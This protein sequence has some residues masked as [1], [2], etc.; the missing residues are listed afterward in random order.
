MYTAYVESPKVLPIVYQVHAAP[1]AKELQMLDCV[2][3]RRNALFETVHPFP[4]YSPLDA[5]E[6][7][8]RTLGDLT[9]IVKPARWQG[10]GS[11]LT[12]LP[13]QGRG[14]YSKVAAEWMLHAGIC[15]FQHCTHVLNASAHHP[16]DY[17]QEALGQG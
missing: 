2:R 1:E 7:C 6:E 3:C 12:I 14:W 11:L 9:F 4:V 17:L 16:K 5:I 8:T 13:Y 15:E 10:G